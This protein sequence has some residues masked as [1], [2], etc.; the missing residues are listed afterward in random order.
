MGKTHEGAVW[1]D[2]ELT[3]PYDY[4]QYWINQDDRDIAR[5]L[6]FFTFLPMDEVRRLGSLQGKELREAKETLAYEATKLCHG[7]EEA[8]KARLGARQ[9][10]GGDASEPS[11]AVPHYEIPP[12][13]LEKGIPAYLLFEKVG[14]CKSRGEA[15]RLISQGGGY[16]NKRR[17][18]TFDEVIDRKDIT[19]D[20]ILLRAGK[21]RY[22]RITVAWAE[23]TTR[24]RS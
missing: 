19:E 12:E 8:E 18:K 1:L 24:L 21:K 2:P 3:S 22:L 6:A 11:E 4:Y 15:R 7:Q 20:A 13:D 17:L 5:F 16:V 9:L 10:F 14:L 23:R